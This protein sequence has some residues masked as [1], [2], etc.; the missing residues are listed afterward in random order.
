MRRPAEFANSASVPATLFNARSSTA[1]GWISATAPES[2][3]DSEWHGRFSQRAARRRAS[4]SSRATRRRKSAASDTMSR[5]SRLLTVDSS[6]S[7]SSV[8][9]SIALAI[10]CRAIRA[11]HVHASRDPLIA[12]RGP[13]D[14]R[15]RSSD[16]SVSGRIPVLFD[17]RLPSACA[18]DDRVCAPYFLDARAR[19]ALELAQVVKQIDGHVAS[20]DFS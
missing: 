8:F 5:R 9:R 20:Q 16:R 19:A 7:A 4:D 3:R 14:G 12:V 13:E 17:A 6:D 11:P 15:S 2:S 1:A 10:A 18:I